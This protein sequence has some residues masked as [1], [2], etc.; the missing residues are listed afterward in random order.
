MVDWK[1]HDTDAATALQC[2]PVLAGSAAAFSHDGTSRRGGT[3]IARLS[4]GQIT[5][6]AAA[7]HDVLTRTTRIGPGSATR[8]GE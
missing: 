4:R 8:T 6:A 3:A 2:A 1:K 7:I 5:I